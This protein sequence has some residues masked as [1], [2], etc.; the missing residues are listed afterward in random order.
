MCGIYASISA[1]RPRSLSEAAKQL[2][3]R[4]G[5]D[6]LGEASTQFVTQDGKTCQVSL[7]SSVLAMR[8][9]HLVAQPFVDPLSG[10][11]LCWNG[12]AW[13]IGTD[14]VNGNDGQAVFDTLLKAS[15][16]SQP[17]DKVLT[18]L[19]SIS[20]PFAF[21][22]LDKTNNSIYFGRDRLGRRSLLFRKETN[23][24]VLELSS[25]GD[26]ST[27][28]WNEIEVETFY[29]LSYGGQLDSIVK[30]IGSP[31]LSLESIGTIDRHVWTSEANITVSPSM[32]FTSKKTLTCDSLFPWAL[33]ICPCQS[34][35]TS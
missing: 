21:V 6:H 16:S 27:G 20:G 12:E 1:Q 4:R 18:V 11:C 34:K 30:K 28:G 17:R 5:P 8:G 10:S 32:P 24:A 26:P 7:L 13:K 15:C 9:G 23:D 31:E 22:Y 3:C 33:S 2:L 25:I 19:R 35:A 29:Q 14:A